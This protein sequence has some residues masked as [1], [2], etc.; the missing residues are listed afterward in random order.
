MPER[1]KQGQV[2]PQSKVVRSLDEAQAIYE[3]RPGASRYPHVSLTLSRFAATSRLQEQ[4]HSCTY[5]VLPRG[6]FH[7]RRLRRTSTVWWGSRRGWLWLRFHRRFRRTSRRAAVPSWIVPST[8]T[9]TTEATSTRP[10]EYADRIHA[11]AP[12]PT[13]SSPMRAFEADD[14]DQPWGRKTWC[15]RTAGTSLAWIAR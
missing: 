15:A 8:F 12:L 7:P 6:L 9:T 5:D 2:A 10:R 4:A 13:S 3:G 14:A 11:G 1:G